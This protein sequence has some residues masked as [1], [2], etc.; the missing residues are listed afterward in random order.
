M[1][2]KASTSSSRYP[3]YGIA[4]PFAA[5]NLNQS[6]VGKRVFPRG[7]K[8]SLKNSSVIVDTS[9]Q[10]S[11]RQGTSAPSNRTVTTGHFPTAFSYTVDLSIFKPLLSPPVTWLLMRGGVSLGT[12][13]GALYLVVDLS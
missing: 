7:R 10:E 6:P 13:Q 12:C 1:T 9:D 2:P 11:K 8:W 4:N 3:T 5:V